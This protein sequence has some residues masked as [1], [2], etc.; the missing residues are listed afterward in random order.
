MKK[1]IMIL[2]A[3]LLAMSL[4]SCTITYSSSSEPQ[5]KPTA[6]SSAEPAPEVSSTAPESTAEEKNYGVGDPAQSRDTEVTVTSVEKSTGTQ[7]DKPKDGMEFVIVTVKYKNIS[8]KNNITYNPFD[9]KI[10]NSQGQITSQ[11]FTMVN[12]DTA[13]SSGE[14]APGGEISGT[15]AFE[16][17]AGDEGLVLQYIGSVFDSKTVEFE[18]S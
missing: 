8:E 6:P 17:P 13:L 7:Y 14:L 18:L 12:T 3:G 9:F 15:I 4:T 1:G 11:T 16:E 10:K 5:D 2:M